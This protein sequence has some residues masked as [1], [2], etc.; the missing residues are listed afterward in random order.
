VSAG[1]L[2]PARR[3]GRPISLSTLE[4]SHDF[5]LIAQCGGRRERERWIRNVDSSAA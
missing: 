3:T 5:A 4:K 2:A 1:R